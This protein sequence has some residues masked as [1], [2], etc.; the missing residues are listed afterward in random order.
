MCNHSIS[1]HVVTVCGR[2]SPG[3]FPVLECFTP[4]NGLTVCSSSTVMFVV[5]TRSAFETV[6]VMVTCAV[7]RSSGNCSWLVQSR[8][9]E[10]EQTLWPAC[11]GV[12]RR[13]SGC[14]LH[15]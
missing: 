9:D 11:S 8:T 4:V 2:C 6:Y 10:P 1:Y 15:L 3:R 13:M 14:P 5:L 12:R 7:H